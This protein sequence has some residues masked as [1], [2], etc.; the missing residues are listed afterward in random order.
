M[1]RNAIFIGAIEEFFF[2]KHKGLLIIVICLLLDG[3]ADAEPRTPKPS[4]VIYDCEC[5]ARRLSWCI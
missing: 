3:H 2:V 5:H 1:G 4:I